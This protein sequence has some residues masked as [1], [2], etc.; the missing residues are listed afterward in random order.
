MKR[1]MI[2][3]GTAADVIDELKL[4]HEMIPANVE[5][6]LPIWEALFRNMPI[7]ALVR[8]LGNLTDKGVFKKKEN[9][10]ILEQK[11]NADA[12]KFGRVHPIVLCS[13]L[14][15]YSEPVSMFRKSSLTWDPVPFV[16]DI[17]EGAIKIAFD[18]VEPTG[19][20]FY[21]AIDISSSM[22]STM[23]NFGNL[24]LAPSEIAA[25]MALAT[26]KSEKFYYT[27]GFSSQSCDFDGIKKGTSFKD[28][29]EKRHLTGVPGHLRGQGTDLGSAIQYAINKEIKADV[30]VFWTDGQSWQGNH[31]SILLNEYR[32]KL[33]PDAKAIYVILGAYSDR[34]TL[35]KP[36]DKNAFDIAGFS[37]ETVKLVQM[38]ADGKL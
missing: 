29:I 26:I 33:N 35:A 22:S 5:R 31:P 18:S 23:G 3:G 38:I 34:A 15:V 37:S 24:G 6:T 16:V 4:T 17:L 25:I 13:A 14:K 20:T 19:K 32:K 9:L 2:F 27:A 7:N 8:N 36:E 28:I 11:F 1:G 30:L 21:H 12:I 10:I